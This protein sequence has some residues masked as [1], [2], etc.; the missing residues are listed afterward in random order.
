M[1]AQPANRVSNFDP[2]TNRGQRIS[3]TGAAMVESTKRMVGGGFPLGSL[4][5]VAWTAT[6]SGAGAAAGAASGKVILTSGTANSGY[7]TVT[8]TQRAR[9]LFASVNNFR[10]TFRL[11]A[12][13]G[14]NTTRSWGAFNLGS[15]PAIND[16]FYFNYD[17]TT[18]TLSVNTI[19]GGVVTN[20]I[21][22][23]SFNGEFT[24][25]TVDTN[26]HNF[27][28]IYQ[29]AAVLFLIDGVL[30]HR[31]SLGSSPMS[32]DM[33]VCTSGLSKNSAS[34]TT[35][36]SLEIWAMSIVRLG[37]ADPGPQ[38]YHI[39]ANG[40]FVIK[41]GPTTI[42]SLVVNTPGAVN[43]TVTIYDNTAASGTIIGV[44]QSTLGSPAT[45]NYGV[46][47]SIGLTIVVATGTAADITV[48]YD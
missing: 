6:S 28:I 11:S 31:F 39:N 23:G 33:S 27:E 41:V 17:G 10:G 16:G 47:L 45:L 36:V 43:N 38:G 7:G 2:Q 46:D 22:S 21:N 30:L 34:G 35:S 15:L 37:A 9:F 8:S 40:T 24:T 5:T 25:Y 14:A 44:V 19:S 32:S 29:V 48:I 26:A 20:T 42:H 4:D 3:P 18:S 12:L 1:I 13:G